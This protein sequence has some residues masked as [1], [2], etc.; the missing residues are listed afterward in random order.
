MKCIVPLAG[1][2][3]YTRKYGLKPAYEIDGEP[4]LFRALHSRN[5]YGHSLNEEDLIFVLRDFEQLNVLK[6]L[7]ASYFPKGRQVIIPDLTCGALM[8][9]LAGTALI[10]NFGEAIAVDLVDILF[11]SDFEPETIF[12]ADKNISGIIPYFRS[13]NHKYSY[14]K[15]SENQDVLRTR[16]KNIISD[17]AS[18]GVYFFRN[19][20]YFL[21][22]LSYSL[23]HKRTLA[24][25]NLLYLCPSFNGL[26]KGSGV[27]KAVEVDDVRDI[28]TFLR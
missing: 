16:E 5:W 6:K 25:K 19:I 9:S 23:E 15:L 7:I 12:N 26:I 10:T 28:S 13:D 14:L 21:K 22:A 17:K 20:H 4:L 3:I 2:D 27:V 8:S 1:P 11:S 18:A 24:F